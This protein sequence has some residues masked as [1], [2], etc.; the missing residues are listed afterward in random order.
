M[1]DKVVVLITCGTRRE[2]KRIA[3]RLVERRLAACVNVLET[4]MRST[5]RWKG[6]VEI[7]AEYLLLVK[8]ARKLLAALRAEVERMH[9]YEVPEVIALPIAGGSAAY[10]RWLGE[11]LGPAR[12]LRHRGTETQR[13][14]K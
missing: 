9:S 3:S 1:T 8:T 6:R 2:A 14:N 12:R 11:C 13:T 7:A 5:Y 10:L 4:P